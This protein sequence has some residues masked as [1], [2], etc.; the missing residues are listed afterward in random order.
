M[1]QEPEKKIQLKKTHTIINN[2]YNQ[3][4]LFENTNEIDKPRT[5]LRK[6]GTN[7]KIRNEK[8]QPE[9]WER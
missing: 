9:I 8:I 4:L 3:E 5:R 6:E 2:K 7:I 1:N